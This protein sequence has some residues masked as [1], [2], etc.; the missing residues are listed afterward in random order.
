M[1]LII[2]IEETGLGNPLETSPEGRPIELFIGYSAFRV[3]NM[4]AEQAGE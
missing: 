3:A 1:K 2:E 4:T